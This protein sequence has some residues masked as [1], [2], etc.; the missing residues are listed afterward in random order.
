MRQKSSRMKRCCFP[1][2]RAKLSCKV[3]RFVLRESAKFKREAAVGIFT[4]RTQF[5]HFAG[6][7]ELDGQ[8]CSLG[9]ALVR[10]HLA[11]MPQVAFTS[12]AGVEIRRATAEP[13]ASHSHGQW[14][15]D[16][17]ADRGTPFREAC[18]LLPLGRP[19]P[20]LEPQMSKRKMATKR[21]RSNPKPAT[22]PKRDRRP[23]VAARAQRKKQ[24]VIRS[25]KDSPL[26]PVAAGSTEAPMDVRDQLQPE[27]PIV[28]NRARA[29][30][31]EAILQASLQNDVGRKMSDNNPGKGFEFLLPLANMQAYQAKLLEVT[32]ANM[33]FAFEFLQRL[34][35]I[36]SPFEV[37]AVIAE[38]T[39]KRIVMIGKH[40]KELAAFWRSDAIRDLTALPGR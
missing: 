16:P 37:W 12:H 1:C 9:L 33:Q 27:T 6:F 2:K 21:V 7:A 10:D 34:A 25:P 23:K 32:Q 38:F 8:L 20:F 40:S 19:P 29:A 13:E 22:S 35:T 26:R 30:A 24:A 31:L 28:D 11:N 5:V 14:H 39:G 3:S 15:R 18:C 17:V 4:K 36:R